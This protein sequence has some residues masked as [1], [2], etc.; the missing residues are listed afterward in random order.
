MHKPVR[1]RFV[2][3]PYIMSNLMEV[4]ECDLLDIRSL[5][6][7]NDMHRYILSVIDVFSKYCICSPKRQR[8]DRPSLMRFDPYFTT[9]T[10]ANLCE[11]ILTRAKNF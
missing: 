8:E 9:M 1:K 10:R 3:K 2:R 6:K 5:V 11:Y 4:W 7:Y